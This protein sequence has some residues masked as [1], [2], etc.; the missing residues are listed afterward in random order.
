MIVM[1]FGGTSV[2]SAERMT[3]V[4]RLVSSEIKRHPVVVTSAMTQVTNQL[5]EMAR[6]A[7]TWQQKA[8]YSS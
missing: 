7:T 5:E 8:R 3:D 6:L 4:A 2:G 1:K